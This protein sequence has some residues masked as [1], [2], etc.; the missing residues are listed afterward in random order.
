M[1]PESLLSTSEASSAN[2]SSGASSVTT[3]IEVPNSGE[4]LLCMDITS[5]D[6]NSPSPNCNTVSNIDDCKGGLSQKVKKK[7]VQKSLSAFS[8]LRAKKRKH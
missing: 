2:T 3:S 8:F 5:I 7:Y 1:S 4:G 6:A